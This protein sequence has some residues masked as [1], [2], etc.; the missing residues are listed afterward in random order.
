[1]K[2]NND[3]VAYERPSVMVF[4]IPVESIICVSPGKNEGTGEEDWGSGVMMPD[5]I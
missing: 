4:S 1:M 3:S 5:L 2:K